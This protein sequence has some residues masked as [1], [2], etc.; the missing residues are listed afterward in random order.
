MVKQIEKHLKEQV[1]QQANHT[2][3]YSL[4]PKKRIEQL[5]TTEPWDDELV[6]RCTKTG[7]SE[8]QMNLETKETQDES[9]LGI[10]DFSEG[11]WQYC[12]RSL[13]LTVQ[14]VQLVTEKAQK[15]FLKWKKK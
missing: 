8:L 11:A 3:L 14:A 13:K 1:K 10:E 7:K 6:I 9:K 15:H 5:S 12:K 2:G 4:S